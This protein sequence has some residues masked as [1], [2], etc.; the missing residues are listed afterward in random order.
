MFYPELK[1]IVVLRRNRGRI[2][3]R[4]LR[5]KFR[6]KSRVFA[7]ASL[8]VRRGLFLRGVALL[9]ERSC[10]WSAHRRRV[11]NAAQC[12][13]M[14]LDAAQ[15]SSMQ[16]DAALCSSMQLNALQCS[17]MQLNAARCSSMS[18]FSFL[19]WVL[20]ETTLTRLKH[21]APRNMFEAPS[22]KLQAPSSKLQAASCKL[23]A[24]SCKLQ[25]AKHVLA[26][27]LAGVPCPPPLQV[28]GN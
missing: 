15:C 16:L 10:S 21:V 28:V 9:E 18:A 17:S 7:E 19:P 1:T 27:P 24:P 4:K 11:P 26:A 8:P 13:S 12:S 14:Q 22:C 23:Q 2:S 3:P 6:L 25:A 5:L 20:Y